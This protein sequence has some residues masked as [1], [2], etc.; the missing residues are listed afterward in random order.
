MSSNASSIVI[1]CNEWDTSKV[2]YMAPKMNER[3]GSSINIIS[4]QTNRG[5]HITTPMMMTWGISDYI[6]EKTGESDGKFTL[7]LAFPNK[8]YENEE[9]RTFLEKFKAFEE[10]IL[11]DAVK[12]STSWW[13]GPPK[14]REVLEFTYFPSLKYSRNRDTHEIDYSRPPGLRAKVPYYGNKWDIE[15]YDLNSNLIFPSESAIGRTPVDFVP[16][17]SYVACVLKCAGIWI[18]GKGWGVSWKCVQCVV[19]PR[20]NMNVMGSGRCF[21]KVSAEDQAAAVAAAA[22]VDS[23]PAAAAPAAQQEVQGVIVDDSDDDEPAAKPAAV[24]P[25]PAP[26]P[27]PAPVPVPEP[28]PEPEP[29]VEAPAPAAAPAEP[30]KKKTVIKKKVVTSA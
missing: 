5:L 15:V 14:S 6:D 28:E 23:K 30:V 16:K 9:T 18:G 22:G 2:K 21:I 24:A 12:N 20:D 3:G 10:Q 4:T 7:S 17:S 11:N 25:T 13:K 26:T 19:K 27:E 1:D 29:V 8:E